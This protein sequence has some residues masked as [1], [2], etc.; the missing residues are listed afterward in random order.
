M[1]MSRWLCRSLLLG[2]IGLSVL[3][4]KARPKAVQFINILSKAN[5]RLNTAAKS[6]EKALQPLRSNMPAN[7][8]AVESAYR[9]MDTA[10]K[11]VKQELSGLQP[12]IRSTPGEELLKAYKSFIDGQQSIFDRQITPAYRTAVGAGDPA[13][14]WAAIQPL[15][16]AAEDEENN[17]YKTLLAA[18]EEYGKHHNLQIGR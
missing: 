1:V 4:C 5:N 10:L 18:Q 12:P 11:D 13:A 15:L 6:F 2:L 14:K 3:G 8:A 16:A 7:N 17:T 9:D